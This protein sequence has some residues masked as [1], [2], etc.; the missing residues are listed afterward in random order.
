MNSDEVKK[1]L[2][3]RACG[4][5]GENEECIN[6][7]AQAEL[8]DI[9]VHDKCPKTN[10][11]LTQIL[12]E[13]ETFDYIYLATYGN[14]NGFCNETRT[15]DFSWIDFGTHLCS[16]MCMNEECIILLSCCRGGLN[17]VAYSL[18]YCC[19]KIAYIVGPR[20]SLYPYDL[21]IGF[22]ILLYNL[23]HRGIDPI[24]ACEKI[25]LGTDIRFVC[26][27][28]LETESEP[29][30]WMYLQRIN[31]ETL[32]QVNQAKEKA[33]ESPAFVPPEITHQPKIQILP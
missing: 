1:M 13:G 20:Q 9:E 30:Y 31:T 8:Y 6:I 23:E 33:N 4:S 28:R 11:E 32:K 19:Q 12:S 26:F 25:K 15:I 29:A 21:L 16:A 10:A 18:F 5:T 7:K 24:V 2:I 22:N 27:D 3:L 17:Q 14:E